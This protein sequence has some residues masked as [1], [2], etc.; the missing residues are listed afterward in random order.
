MHF[1]VR[2]PESCACD[3]ATMHHTNIPALRDK[4]SKEEDR[5]A[6]TCPNP[7]IENIGRRSIEQS[8]VL[9]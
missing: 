4:Y 5:Q 1:I 3:G 8:L 2:T 6:Y 9:L 7:P